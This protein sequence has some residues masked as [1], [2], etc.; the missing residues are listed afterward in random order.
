MGTYMEVKD[1]QNRTAGGLRLS[2][3]HE[4]QH[5]R[6]LRTRDALIH[7]HNPLAQFV[8]LFLKYLQA[9]MAVRLVV[10]EEAD[11]VVARKA[12]LQWPQ[13]ASFSELCIPEPLHGFR[14]HEEEELRLAF[15]T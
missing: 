14:A 3:V 12:T 2:P 7:V 4:V 10:F 15:G 13:L 9:R 1:L 5:E 11:V 8:G 6:V